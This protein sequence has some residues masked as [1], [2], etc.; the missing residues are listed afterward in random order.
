MIPPMISWKQRIQ[1]YCHGCYILCTW[2]LVRVIYFST[3]KEIWD[4]TTQTY[5]K[6]RSAARNTLL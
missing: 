1:R 3:S 6:M 2:I 4:A 5:S